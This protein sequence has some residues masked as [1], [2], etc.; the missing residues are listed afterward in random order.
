MDEQD[1]Q[2][3]IT[4]VDEASGTLDNVAE[5]A[6]GMATAINEAADII[7][8]S[9]TDALS[10]VEVAA[11][12]S[13]LASAEA[14]MG[15]TDDITE[16]AAAA[17]ESLVGDFDAVGTASRDSALSSVT[18]WQTS[19]EEI[20]AIGAM[21]Q[22]EVDAAFAGMG[23]AAEEGATKAESAMHG[24]GSYFRTLIAGYMFET[25]GSSITGFVNQI[26]AAAAGGDPN[27][28]KD[29]QD[30]LATL[31]A[32]LDKQEQPISGKGKTTGVLGADEAAQAAQIETT[33][34]KIIELKE[35]LDPLAAAQERAGASA[36]A[37]DQATKS[38]TQDWQTFLA[39][40]GT[41]LLSNLA[42]TADWVD[43]I[44]KSVTAWAV[45]NPEMSKDILTFAGTIGYLATAIGGLTIAFAFLQLI[46]SPELLVFLAV[47]TA[48]AV[49]A[50]LIVTFHPQ[51]M[52]FL[53][54]L[55]A[56]TGIVDT[57]KKAWNEI[58]QQFTS[59]L[60][61]ALKQLWDAFQPYMPFLKELAGVALVLV[62]AGLKLLV[63]WVASGVTN[64]TELLTILTK[65]ETFLLDKFAPAIKSAQDG[66]GSLLNS[67]GFKSISG[68]SGVLGSITGGIGSALL[69]MLTPFAG[70]GI[71]NSPTMAL[72]GEAGP[73]AVIPLSAFNGGSSLSGGGIGGGAGNIIVNITGTFLSQDAARQLSQ[74]MI[75]GLNR[76]VRLRAAI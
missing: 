40:V 72:I 7:Q 12:D 5:S 16:S 62:I 28:I 43:G 53:D 37:Y 44:V 21:T 34:Q 47:S 38:L 52:A 71:V 15:A 55:N 50:A 42:S 58:S 36:V 10:A 74:M 49:I 18:P 31:E 76:Q 67:S 75:T 9:M 56:K 39:T 60:L 32:Q 46:M 17:A 66:I 29:L 19:F 70:G 73:E 30:Q 8:T 51:L 54:E 65:I 1:L 23:T 63:G 27:K 26:V 64:F 13:S 35:Q 33:K 57:F 11:I 3:N 14:W 25:V 69:G 41:P 45:K 24:M 48:I 2:I 68:N 22:E 6:D 59:Q 4:A 61:P 20:A